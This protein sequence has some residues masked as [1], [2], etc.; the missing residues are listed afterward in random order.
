MTC[1]A[2]WAPRAKQVDLV[3]GDER[4][5][6]KQRPASEPWREGWW[7]LDVPSAGVG[8][9]YAYSLDGGT[10][11]PDPRSWHQPRTV[12]DAS[13][14]VDPAL[15]HWTDETWTGLTAPGSVAY[16]LHIGTFT[17]EGTFD[18]A[19]GRL[20]HLAQ[21]GVDL[22]ELMP[23]TAFPGTHGWGYDGVAP[24]SVHEPYG[25]PSGLVRFID[26]CH[27]RGIGVLLDV[28]YNH[29]GP[30][31]NYLA[32]FGPYFTGKH[33]TPWGWAV[34]LDDSG[35]DEVRAY[36]V[37]NALHWLRDYHL[38]GLRLDAVHALADTRSVHVLEQLSIA[39]DDLAARLGRPL[40][41]IAET[42][43]NDPRIIT[44]RTHSGYGVHAQWNDDFHHALHSL[45]TGERHGYYADFGSI[46]AFAKTL[47]SCYF[48]DGSWSSFRGRT[49]GRPVDTV[50]IG[51]NRFV[52]FLQD[53]D[54]VGNRALGD[55]IGAALPPGR[56]RIGAALLLTA[57]FTPML[58]MGEEWGAS[59]PWQYFC[60]H[61]DP[62]LGGAIR[63]GRRREFARHGWAGEDVPDPQAPET[64]ARSRLDWNEIARDEHREL[65][66]WYRAL[67]ALR[68]S[69][70]DLQDPRLTAVRVVYDEPAQWLVVQRGA[71]RVAV[72]L[73]D[74]ARSIRLD[75]AGS[76]VLLASDAAIRI[77][78]GD[79]DPPTFGTSGAIDTTRV[80]HLHLPAQSVAIV[81]MPTPAW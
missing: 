35:S 43:L 47:T 40:A 45:L 14:V 17:R 61:P 62:E 23:I 28:V 25:G 76:A 74:R 42:D 12:H 15:F 4:L 19:I 65:L 46:C 20:D 32:E 64:F 27:R 50:L 39:V 36:I 53:H 7:E 49:H 56:R 38:D 81:R 26:A 75:A 51:A 44:P 8:T 67:I 21:L 11:R 69:E 30:S 54:Q 71:V 58:F 79:A 22:V 33:Q 5:P 3:L 66:D 73:A 63:E 18:A 72:N 52:C 16:E 48:H 10:P 70:P 60:D 24:W 9:D 6:M 29:L 37:E 59:T 41:L 31:G 77:D 13:R 80:D 55:R 34:N 68:H 1:F 2:V 78:Q 57:P